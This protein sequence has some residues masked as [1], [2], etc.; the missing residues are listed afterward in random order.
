[1][2]D[3]HVAAWPFSC[4]LDRQAVTYEKHKA[5]WAGISTSILRDPEVI[6]LNS[7]APGRSAWAVFTLLIAAARDQNNKGV[8]SSVLEASRLISISQNVLRTSRNAIA[9]NCAKFGSVPWVSIESVEGKSVGTLTVHKF[10]KHHT[11]RGW[12]G[13]RR[14]LRWRSEQPIKMKS[15]SYHPGGVY[16][17]N[18]TNTSSPGLGEVQEGEGGDLIWGGLAKCFGLTDTASVKQRHS[19]EVEALR[20]L[21]A[22]AAEIEAR[23]DN[24]PRHF[25]GMVRTPA[26]LVR[27][28][29]L[30][31]QEPPH[32]EKTD[33]TRIEAE[34]DKYSRWDDGAG[35][36]G[37]SDPSGP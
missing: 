30:L 20:D 29:D 5:P 3:H 22:T 25:V 19:A 17:N 31:A 9:A 13:D 27:H 33:P 15:S 34:S 11:D 32:V 7:T 36:A 35:A 10:L 28:W 26:A 14:S 21:K 23:F 8:F 2:P 6:E 1:M 12:G 4:I 37:G 16:N 18:N 24:Y